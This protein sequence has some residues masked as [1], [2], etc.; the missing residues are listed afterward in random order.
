[1]FFE[2]LRINDWVLVD[3][4]PQHVVGLHILGGERVTTLAPFMSGA[5]IYKAD[6]LNAIPLTEELLLNIGFVQ[7]PSGVSLVKRFEIKDKENGSEAKIWW[8]PDN[9]IEIHAE[10]KYITIYNTISSLNNLQH[11]LSDVGFNLEDAYFSAIL[12]LIKP[13]KD[14]TEH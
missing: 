7:L 1:M 2:K 6:E 9:I 12:T 3:G 10:H 5:K 4:Q 11:V 8:H 14:E 13:V